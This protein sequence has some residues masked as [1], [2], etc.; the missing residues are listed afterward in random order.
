MQQLN[1]APS[2]AKGGFLPWYEA[3]KDMLDGQHGRK[4]LVRAHRAPVRPGRASNALLS[5]A[6]V[7]PHV[8]TKPLHQH[9]CN[10]RRGIL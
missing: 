3:N 10:D 5:D 8:K 1:P 4:V 2:M 9:Q 7:P 6:K